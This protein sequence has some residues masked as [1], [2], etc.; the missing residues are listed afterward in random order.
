MIVEGSLV[1]PAHDITYEVGNRS[2]DDHEFLV[3]VSDGQ[4]SIRFVPAGAT[5]P[6]S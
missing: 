4:L 1:L 5:R 3:G 6:R 2:A